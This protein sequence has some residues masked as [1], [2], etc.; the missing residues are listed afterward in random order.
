MFCLIS[1]EY[2][3]VIQ[4]DVSGGCSITDLRVILPSR[5]GNKFGLVRNQLHAVLVAVLECQEEEE[6]QVDNVVSDKCRVIRKSN[7][8][9]CLIKDRNPKS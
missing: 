7:C 1:K 9:D 2:F 8:R 4:R 3:L 6:F 5:K